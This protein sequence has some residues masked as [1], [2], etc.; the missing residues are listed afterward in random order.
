MECVKTRAEA[1][2][3]DNLDDNELCRME[4]WVCIAEGIAEYDYYYHITE[5]MEQPENEYG[6]NYDENGRYYTPMRNSK[7]RY[8]RR[9]YE[10]YDPDWSE[11]ERMRD[12][13]RKNGRMYYTDMNMNIGSGSSRYDRARRG[14]EESK[15]NH[16]GDNESNMKAIETL[17]DVIDGDM[18]E[19]KPKMT[20]SEKSMAKN[21]LMSLANT[22]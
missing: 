3:L 7:G 22:L 20:Q 15:N 13:D 5:A 19:L 18:Q 8:T 1:K 17:F 10:M 12:M 11:M 2:G 16:S 9:G 4:K 6:V 14:Y 21:K